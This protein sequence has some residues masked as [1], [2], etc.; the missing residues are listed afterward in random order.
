MNEQEL[1][2]QGT[3][4]EVSPEIGEA[5]GDVQDTEVLEAP[6]IEYLDVND[7]L[8]GKYVRIDREGKEISVSLREALDGYNVNS[9]ATQRFQEAS[10]LRQESEQAVRLQQALTA[11]P[12]ITVQYLAQKAGVSV[13]Q[14]LGMSESQ[15]VAATED[16]DD[17]QYQDP[18]E[19]QIAEERTARL[20]LQAQF[21]QQQA[22]RELQH[23]V[24]GLK[25]QFQIDDNQARAVVNQAFQMGA[26]IEMLP[27][28]YQS[29]A[30]AAGQQ[31]QQTSA[32]QQQQAEA[33]RR[34]AVAQQAAVVSPA[35][36]AVGTTT[37]AGNKSFSTIREAV[38][39][40]YEDVERRSR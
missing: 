30:Y 15:H 8:A 21:D 20:L 40:A 32:S 22:D 3:E 39:G 37:D 11:N 9:V 1:A 34:S 2:P 5:G 13:Q 27:M 12:G 10:Q 29:M 14:F 24:G 16:Y 38:M 7:E 31:A 28:I 36:S 25:A 33:Q 26:G 18:L 6:Q 17:D 19:R 4:T 35:P 23:A